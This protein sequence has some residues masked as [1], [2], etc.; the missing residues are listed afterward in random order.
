MDRIDELL[1]DW[2]EW[3]EGYAPKLSF[4]SADPACRDFRISRQWMEYDDL[5]DEVERNRKAYVGKLIE[6]MVQKLDM[7]YRLAVNTAMRN[8]VAGAAVWTNPRHG[9]TQDL[10][11]AFA[12]EILGPQ[13]LSAGLIARDACKTLERVT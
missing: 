2:Y 8:F 10:D 11:Y 9:D 4:G 3:Q 1:I 12:K 6:P 5:N 7:R 13:M